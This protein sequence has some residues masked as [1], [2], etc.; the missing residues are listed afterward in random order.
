VSRRAAPK[1]HS[2]AV[3]STE[4]S[5]VSCLL[6]PV[7]AAAPAD[8][9]PCEF[10]VQWAGSAWERAQA[11]ALRRAVFCIEQGIFVGDDRDAIDARAQALVALSLVGG[12]PDA[13]VGTVRIHEEEAGLWWGSRLAVHA[14][15]RHHGRIGA[16]LI[17]LAVCSAHARG[18]QRFLAHVQGQNVALFERLHWRRLEDLVLHGLMQADLAHYPPC[19]DPWSGFV[20]RSGSAKA[21]P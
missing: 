15:F 11:H 9:T 20:T 6:E 1:A 18:A 5:P 14:A 2:P 10:R 4:G 17:R 13:V 19:H 16:T 8:Y 3:R 7:D 12:S 21:A